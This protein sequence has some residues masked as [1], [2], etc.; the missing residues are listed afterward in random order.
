MNR[1]RI[2][3]AIRAPLRVATAAFALAL[4]ALPALAEGRVALVIGNGGY[5]TVPA[6]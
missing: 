5:E 1:A 2:R 6:G 4:A 3:L